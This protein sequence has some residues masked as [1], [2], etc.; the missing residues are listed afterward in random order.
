MLRRLEAARLV[1]PL[2]HKTDSAN[3]GGLQTMKPLFLGMF[4]AMFLLATATS[5]QDATKSELEGTWTAISLVTTDGKK[6]DEYAKTISWTIVGDK[7]THKEKLITVRSTIKVDA[8]KRPKTFDVE[9]TGPVVTAYWA[10]IYELEGDTLR[11]CYTDT[12]NA[13]RPKDF[14]AKEAVLLVLKREKQ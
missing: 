9:F 12:R 2:R 8:R 7:F 10:G 4:P 3:S 14:K 13:E 11:V 6:D 1:Y 5:A